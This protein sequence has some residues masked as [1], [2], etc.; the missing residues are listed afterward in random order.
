MSYIVYVATLKVY[1]CT[2]THGQAFFQYSSISINPPSFTHFC[3]CLA[4]ITFQI[5]TAAA[6]WHTLKQLV[7]VC[8]LFIPFLFPLISFSYH[9][10]V[11]SFLWYLIYVCQIFVFSFLSS[12]LHSRNI[13]KYLSTH[14][15][16]VAQFFQNNKFYFTPLIYISLS[17]DNQ[18]STSLQPL[19]SSCTLCALI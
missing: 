2:R 12:R 18:F 8:A 11:N 19:T 15:L 1:F 14:V 17:T 3:K 5:S 9:I 13:L 16:V 4:S 7:P 6:H 10:S